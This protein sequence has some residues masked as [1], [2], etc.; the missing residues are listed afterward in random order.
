M[1]KKNRNKQK[2]I[3]KLP[4][5]SNL[6]PNFKTP[7][8]KLSLSNIIQIISTSK[9]IQLLFF[10]TVIGC[11][12]RFYNLGFNSLW[13]DEASTLTF[14]TAGSF[15][16]IWNLTVTIEPNPP[17]F[18]WIEYI[19][20][21][22]GNSEFVLRFIPALAGTI[23][24]PVMYFIGKDFI[25]ENGGLIAAAAFAVSPF[26]I[27]YSQ[28][29]R[30]Y[31]LLLLFIAL[32]ILFYFRALKDTGYKYWIL[33]SIA[34]AFAFWTHFYTAIFLM[35]LIIY[36]F[37][38]YKMKYI[39]ELVA[40]GIILAVTILPLG[41]MSIPTILKSKSGGPTFGIQGI[42]VV[43]DTLVQL[44]GFNLL[45]TYV[46]MLLFVCGIV[47]L[48]IKEREKCVFILWILAFTFAASVI[49][50]F[51]IPMVP[52]YL[53]FLE[54]MIVLGIASSY[55]IFYTLT[56]HKSVTYILILMITIL[57]APVIMSYYSGYTKDDWRGFSTTL[58]STTQP[59][60]IIVIVPG[61][62]SQPLNYYYSNSTDGTIEYFASTE[63]GL[64]SARSEQTKNAYYIVTGDIL[65]ANPNGD[66]LRW[67]QNNTKQ[68]YQNNNI[69]V[70]KS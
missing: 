50:S 27:M 8:N 69:L 68:V 14:A 30:A 57:N 19:M 5:T 1:S 31:S 62:N 64:I 41:I 65:S 44:T 7:D 28:E 66:A 67:I 42:N 60:D 45:I 58:S 36:T 2:S 55:K 3:S 35:A 13:L 26:L 25:D 61:Y 21:Y 56:H 43:I 70:F 10:I 20:L 11:F 48:Y 6:D 17:L 63:T 22:F 59:G 29:A 38:I 32:S 40:S 12:I 33:F 47:T 49:L 53:I 18:H 15:W 39:K 4:E 51:K 46:M 37:A 23:T 16:D 24:I 9:Y 52:R 34:S 54:I